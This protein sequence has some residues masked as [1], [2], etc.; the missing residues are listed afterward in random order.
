MRVGFQK[1]LP[2]GFVKCCHVVRRPVLCAS[3][4][5]LL[6][7]LEAGQRAHGYVT[8]VKDYG[9]FIA[10][11]GGVKGLAP[12]AELGLEPNLDATTQFPNGKVGLNSRLLQKNPSSQQHPCHSP[13]YKKGFM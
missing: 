13:V 2:Y 4:N 6:Q 11:C 1:T 12:Q 9:V 10:F 7:G 5:T 3:D 8:G